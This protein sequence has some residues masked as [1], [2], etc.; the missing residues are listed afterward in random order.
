[1][2]D[3]KRKSGLRRALKLA[4]RFPKRLALVKRL[5]N[6]KL[7]TI[8]DIRG[9]GSDSYPVIERINFGRGRYR[10]YPQRTY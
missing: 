2:K 9:I 8:Q 3:S 7:P 1:M 5:R 6:K 10:L 4:R